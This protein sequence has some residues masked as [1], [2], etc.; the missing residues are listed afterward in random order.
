[1]TEERG[2]AALP[3]WAAEMAA[4]Y[5]SGAAS[6]FVL[7]GNVHD[8]V[9]IPQ[10]GA[11][12]LGGLE[13][14]LL[15]VLLRTFDVV[16]TYDVG[17]GL[18]IAR[19]GEVFARWPSAPRDDA[20]PRPPLLAVQFLTHYF[21]Y[22]A[23]LRRLGEAAPQVG[24][25]VRGAQLVCPAVPYGGSHEL[26]A[27]ALLVREWST[28]SALVEHPLVTVLVTESLNDLHPLVA[29]NARA[30]W[31]EVPLPDA[32][33]LA[34]A[35][36]LMAPSY[37]AAL[38]GFG[39]RPDELAGQLQGATLS[40]VESLLRRREHA[41]RPLDADDL[42]HLK[43]ELVE[44]DNGQLVEF[45]ESD[46]TLDDL[47]GQARLKDW[48]RQ[49]L[50]LWRRGDVEALPMGYLLCGPVGTGKTFLVKCLAGEAGV[51][52]V[53]LGNFRDRWVGSTEAN[54]ER[55]FRL[56]H[57]LGRCFV[58]VDE[59]DQTPGRREGGAGDSGLSGRVYSMMA[60]EMGRPSNRGR[61]VWVLASSRPDLIEVDLKRPGR[62]DVKI[63][64][65]P[66]A[67]A[68]EGYELIA[69]LCRR[70]GIELPGR[71]REELLAS[72]PELLTAGAAE[73]LAVKAY[74]HV[75]TRGMTPLDAV[76]ECLT[77]YRSPVP[78]AVM[79]FQMRLALDEASDEDFVPDAI[80][81]RY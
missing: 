20:L 36:R 58:F 10:P 62:V 61:I 6:Q 66:A 67:D 9:V 2:G 15:H 26:S 48:L 51:P 38:G 81:A 39:A 14:F 44:R 42:V 47:H 18:R 25:V 69:A 33:E 54:L 13:D 76:R 77:D 8:R 11:P 75:R 52:I 59:A 28:D 1:M 43:K 60:Q 56:L 29:T 46:L 34:A 45:I 21:R 49:D 5:E 64:I 4:L 16:L 50:E 7:H 35:L 17:N 72:V 27:Q 24:L 3:T 71:A 31:I 80:R 30:P 79:D 63:P 23:N 41:R 68:E 57:G 32:A 40:A 53:K 19:G 78:A 37:E 73:T 12:R 74:R 22:C 55:I 65:L 70:R